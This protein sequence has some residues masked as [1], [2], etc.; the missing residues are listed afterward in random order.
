MGEGMNTKEKWSE[1]FIQGMLAVKS[2]NI[3]LDTEFAY[4]DIQEDIRMDL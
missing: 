4:K 2:R 3:H 1:K